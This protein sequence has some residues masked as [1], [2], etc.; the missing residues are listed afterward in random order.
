MD[1]LGGMDASR[2]CFRVV[3]TVLVERN[4]GEVKE[5]L[6]TE[7]QNVPFGI[8][9]K[10]VDDGADGAVEHSLKGAREADSGL[11]GGCGTMLSRVDKVSHC[12]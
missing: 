4:V 11:R 10:L 5:A 8:Q 3:D 2:R 9:T 6:E 1:T 12:Q 7:K